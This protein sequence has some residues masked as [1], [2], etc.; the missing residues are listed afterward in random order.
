MVESHTIKG[1]TY[2]YR[3]V[4]DERN[5]KNRSFSIKAPVRKYPGM[6]AWYFAFVPVKT[7]AFIK[8]TFGHAARG[9]GS[10]RVKA[11]IGATSWE[12]SIF[13]DKKSRGYL[14]PLKAVVRKAENV[15]VGKNV[16]LSL[17]IQV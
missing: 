4:S 8:K 7:S 6:D 5:Q 11:A 14:L 10:L 15:R 13:P 2:R 3:F 16:A 9:W 1:V 12:T 17:E